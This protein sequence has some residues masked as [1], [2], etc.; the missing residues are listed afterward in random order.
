MSRPFEAYFDDPEYQQAAVIDGFKHD[1]S[2]LLPVAIPVV[3]Q[4]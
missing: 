1:F 3:S 2:F 4:N